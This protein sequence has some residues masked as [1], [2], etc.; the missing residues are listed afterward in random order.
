VT[1][2]TR[3]LVVWLLLF[4]CLW[5]PLFDDPPLQSGAYVQDVGTDRATVAMITAGPEVRT[6]AVTD[7]EGRRVAEQAPAAPRRR[8]AFAL[9]GLQAGAT[10]RYEIQDGGGAVCDGG[11]FRTAPASDAEPVRFAV[12][13]DSG[14]VP[15][16]VW[17][18]RNALFH[19]PARWSW[20]PPRS[21]VARTGERLAAAKP[22]F[23]LHLGDIVYPW[24]HQ[25]HYRAAFFAPF[26]EVLRSAPIYVALGNHDV[27][28]DEGR[29]ALAN[30]FL[31][32]NDVTGDERC[33]SLVWG[34]VR[35]IVLDFGVQGGE[36]DRA[37]P[38]HPSLAVL[39]RELAACS[40]PWVVV[41]SHYPIHSASRQ[42]DRADLAMTVLP[43]LQQHE[44]D[45]YLCGHDHT[46]QRFGGPGE[47]VQ[48]VSGGG[49]KDLYAVRP[50][51]RA[52]VVQS[53][54]HWCA[55]EAKGRTLELR[56]WGIDGARIDTVELRRE[57]SG[58]RFERLQ[59]VNPARA[60][61]VQRLL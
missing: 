33:Y 6:I 56:A 30:F 11:T 4:G 13:G 21:Q 44:V 52:Q 54:H 59:R 3:R 17:L 36:A 31:P 48:V 28:D 60:A 19:L 1:V 15:W 37:R 32:R 22:D 29:Q 34:S 18:Q 42:G 57:A 9:T 5:L 40:E 39:E 51:P 58:E 43:L 49:G 8:H 24:G 61:R 25:A 45:L 35:V 2:R 41:A 38:G 12:L 50:D 14:A 23:V 26:A 27:M 47:L 55:V 7:A 46:Y 10:Y 16:W 53:Q 20:L